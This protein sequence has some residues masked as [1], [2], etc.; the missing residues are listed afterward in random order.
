MSTG[1]ERS[2]EC[3]W[4]LTHSAVRDVGGT[5]RETAVEQ[6]VTCGGK[7]KGCGS[8]EASDSGHWEAMSVKVA[9]ESA[10]VNEGMT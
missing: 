2:Q 9:W 7:L 10:R 6:L 3:V 8:L 1:R 5:S 4:H